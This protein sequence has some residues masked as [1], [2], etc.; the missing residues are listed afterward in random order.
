[1]K[2]KFFFG[3]VFEDLGLTKGDIVLCFEDGR[4]FRL[5]DEG[6]IKLFAVSR[7]YYLIPDFIFMIDIDDLQSILNRSFYEFFEKNKE[8][9][10][11]YLIT[12]T[13]ITI[14]EFSAYLDISKD[15]SKEI[16]NYLISMNYIRKYYHWYKLTDTGKEEIKN[17]FNQ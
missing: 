14:N 11:E 16:I 8:K 13:T 3:D 10:Y 1:M 2:A 17:Y 7:N 4:V 6:K 15:L 5:N 12:S 9:I